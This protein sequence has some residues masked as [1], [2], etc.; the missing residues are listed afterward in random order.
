MPHPLLTQLPG[1]RPTDVHDA[2]EALLKAS[3]IPAK[4]RADKITGVIDI[5]CRYAFDEG[6]DEDALRAVARIASRKTELD[7]T[8][9]TTLVKNMYPAQRVPADVVVTI[10]GALGQGKGKPSP[11][12]QSSLVKWLTIVHEVVADANVLSRLYAVLFR[13]LDM[14]S[15][16]TSLCHLLSLITR[17]KHVKPFR[18]QQLLE[19]SR[20]LSN[21]PALQGLLRVYKDYY[22]DIILGST[23]TSRHSFPPGPDLEWRTRLDAIK[24]ARN[25]TDEPAEEH[26]GFKV[27]RKG[28]K[29]SKISLIPDVHTYYST[30]ASVTLEEIDNV[31]DFVEKLDRI[32]PPGQMISLL[33]D[34]LLQKYIELRPT[35][36]SV[37][38]ID[39]WL[40]TCLDDQY[41]AATSGTRSSTSGSEVFEG[42]LKQTRCT[43]TLLPIT[44]TFLKAYLV[45][46]DGLDD[47]DSILGLLSYVPV[48]PF[49]EAYTTYFQPA[50]RAL[51]ASSSASYSNLIQF[52]TDIL[53]F[54]VSGV[55]PQSSRPQSALSSGDQK[56]LHQLV[57]HV[58]DMATSLLLSVP[59]GEGH[60]LTSSIL[61]F[62]EVLSA[63][64][65]PYHV[66][67]LVPPV[68][69]TYYLVLDNSTTT[70]SRVYGILGTYK[71]AF[72]QHPKP[73]TAHYPTKMID[74]FNSCLTDM[75][76][77]LWISRALLQAPN[78]KALG[79]FCKPSLRDDLNT[80]LGSIDREY[81]IAS[82]FG[83]SNNAWLTSLSAATWRS[84]E[85]A[86]IDKNGYDRGSI[87]LHQGPVSQRSLAV[88]KKN[89]GV[90]VD[91]EKYKVQVLHWLAERGCGGIRD[92]M[93]AA[94]TDLKAMHAQQ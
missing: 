14:Y 84:I 30:E 80:Y 41:N 40:S 60:T 70:L 46:W 37:R 65:K 85:E 11:G 6:L 59:P 28:P 72:D 61:T 89:G 73:V 25:I 39:L 34:P 51:T 35:P 66:P 19:L 87:N 18:I 90:N 12:T 27:L 78:T 4:Q 20:G 75:F 56:S 68:H 74:T 26:G 69:L 44:D 62:Y 82:A 31:D 2:V 9:V 77:L 71:R 52:Y 81:A 15:I 86:E 38:R 10:V 57:T 21:E 7:Q 83:V 33:H 24:E 29:R 49:P 88:L 91:W 76:N 93:F 63:S 36:T 50:E 13:M 5:V 3:G 8:S 55:T 42:L 45:V 43:N 23:S 32:E 58:S 17:R 67:I 1:E 94:K 16:R 48:Q 54:W 22:P 47:V 53:G 64:A 79:L 92:F